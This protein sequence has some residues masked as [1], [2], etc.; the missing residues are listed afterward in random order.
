M[1]AQ[2]Y[3]GEAPASSYGAPTGTAYLVRRLS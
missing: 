1:R 2:Q 3:A